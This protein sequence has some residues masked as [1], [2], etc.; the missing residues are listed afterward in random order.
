MQMGPGAFL[1]PDLLAL[2]KRGIRV[3]FLGGLSYPRRIYEGVVSSNR[4]LP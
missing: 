1:G 4:I 3:L 2:E